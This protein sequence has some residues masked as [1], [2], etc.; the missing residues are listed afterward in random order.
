VLTRLG[1]SVEQVRHEVIR[2]VACRRAADGLTEPGEGGG[3]Q[4]A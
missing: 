1:A 4:S 2:H 3:Q